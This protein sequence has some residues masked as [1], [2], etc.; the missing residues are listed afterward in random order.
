MGKTFITAA[1]NVAELLSKYKL[2]NF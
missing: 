2:V 1:E